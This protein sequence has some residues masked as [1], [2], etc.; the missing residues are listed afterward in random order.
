MDTQYSRKQ[1]SFSSLINGVCRTHWC[2]LEQAKNGL[3]VSC[4]L[5][6]MNG[7][8]T[9]HACIVLLLNIAQP[10]SLGQLASCVCGLQLF[11]LPFYIAE[12]PFQAPTLV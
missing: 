4:K 9:L 10:K 2:D 6:L 3:P 8:F 12:H 5:E 7:R 11:A 1:A